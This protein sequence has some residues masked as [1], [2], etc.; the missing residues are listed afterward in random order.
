MIREHPDWSNETIARQCGFSDRTYFQRK[1]KE[2]TGMTPS[3]YM[4][5]SV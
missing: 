5:K 3:E 2:I 4:N 1:F